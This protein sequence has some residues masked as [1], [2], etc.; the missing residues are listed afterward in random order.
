L[1]FDSLYKSVC[2]DYVSQK[3][4]E[5]D[6]TTTSWTLH[7]I[8]VDYSW[9]HESVDYHNFSIYTVTSLSVCPTSGPLPLL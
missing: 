2:I 8:S 4:G 1:Q 6:L 3:V 9:W 7:S 5:F